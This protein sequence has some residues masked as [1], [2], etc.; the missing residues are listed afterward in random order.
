MLSGR[1]AGFGR[2]QVGNIAGEGCVDHLDIACRERTA[3]RSV[4]S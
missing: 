2:P 4:V 1:P 3:P